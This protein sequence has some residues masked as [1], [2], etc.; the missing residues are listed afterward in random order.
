MGRDMARSMWDKKSRND[1]RTGRDCRKGCMPKTAV[2]RLE[3]NKRP[4][5][6][7]ATMSEEGWSAGY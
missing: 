5:H 7:T 2:V 3:A 4:R 6:Q 1:E